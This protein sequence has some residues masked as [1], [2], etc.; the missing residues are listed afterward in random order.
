MSVARTARERVHEEVSAEI[1]AVARVHLA[2]DGAAALSLRSIARDVQMVPSALYRYYSGRDALLSALILS[3]YGSL[4][5]EA[6]AAAAKAKG[7]DAESWLAVPRAMRRWALAHPHEWSLIFGTPVP[8]YQSPPDTVVP[9]A[10]L[11]TA[12]VHPLV[13]ASAAGRL[14][15]SDPDA[16]VSDALRDAI[17]PVAQAVLPDAPTI[18]VL[19][20]LES[21]AALIGSISLELFGHWNNTV[22][23]PEAFFDETVRGMAR[24]LGL[25]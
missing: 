12:L 22:L 24:S 21:W 20:A 4:A 19:R 14:H 18:I 3:A 6:E 15:A 23:D 8:G 16:S 2:R 17:A 13:E 7:S 1:L 9:Y 11:A 10:R 5:D 25:R